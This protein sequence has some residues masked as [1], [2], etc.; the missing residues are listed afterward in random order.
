MLVTASYY[1]PEKW[2][3]QSYR[4]SLGYPR[5][6]KKAWKDL[7]L[8]AP[9][10]ETVAAYRQGRIDAQRYVQEYDDLLRSR[11]REVAA[12]LGSL[13]PDDDVTLLC[14]EREGEFCHRHLIAE[15]VRRL[16]PELPVEEH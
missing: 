9:E 6:R 3:G 5:G 4:I 12:W 10:R 2:R 14:F 16:R 13:K 11:W 15:L 7:P 8:L 1:E